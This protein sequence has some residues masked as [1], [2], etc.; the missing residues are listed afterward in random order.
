MAQLRPEVRPIVSSMPVEGFALQTGGSAR[1]RVVPFDT[2]S[3]SYHVTGVPGHTH[4]TSAVCSVLVDNTER[5]NATFTIHENFAHAAVEHNAPRYTDS[6]AVDES[7]YDRAIERGIG[8]IAIIPENCHQEIR[9]PVRD[10][11]EIRT[12]VTPKDKLDTLT[13]V[14]E[15]GGF[16]DQVTGEVPEDEPTYPDIEVDLF[17][18]YQ[19]A[20]EVNDVVPYDDGNDVGT[21]NAEFPGT[22]LRFESDWT[23]SEFSRDGNGDGNGTSFAVLYLAASPDVVVTVDGVSWHGVVTF[24]WD[25]NRKVYFCPS[26]EA[27]F[28]RV[29]EAY[30]VPDNAGRIEYSRIHTDFEVQFPEITT[31]VSKDGQCVFAG[32][33]RP[34]GTG[35]QLQPIECT[36]ADS[37]L[38]RGIANSSVTFWAYPF[39]IATGYRSALYG[40]GRTISYWSRVRNTT[41]ERIMERVRDQAIVGGDLLNGGVGPEHTLLQSEICRV[42]LVDEDEIWRP[43]TEMPEV[44]ARNLKPGTAWSMIPSVLDTDPTACG[45]SFDINN[46]GNAWAKTPNANAS[47]G[48]QFMMNQLVGDLMGVDGAGTLNDPAWTNAA[49]WENHNHHN[50]YRTE[51][52]IDTTLLLHRI[53]VPDVQ[54][55]P[56]V[57]PLDHFGAL[58][59]ARMV[60]A[61]TLAKI[62]ITRI[63]AG[64]GNPAQ[65]PVVD[66]VNFQSEDH[67]IREHARRTNLQAFANTAYTTARGITTAHQ[68]NLNL[69]TGQIANAVA[70]YPTTNVGGVAPAVQYNVA[71]PANPGALAAVLALI[72]PI[73]QQQLVTAQAA[74][75][76]TLE[77]LQGLVANLV[78][79]NSG[80]NFVYGALPTDDKRAL[81]PSPTDADGHPATTWRQ[82]LRSRY[83]QAARDLVNDG[84][85]S[86]AKMITVPCTVRYMFADKMVSWRPA[87]AG[88]WVDGSTIDTIYWGT[89]ELGLDVDHA[90][91]TY[92]QQE[93]APF[94]IWTEPA[95]VEGGGD[96]QATG[97][98]IGIDTDL[99]ALFDI[100]SVHQDFTEEADANWTNQ[101]GDGVDAV[102][103]NTRRNNAAGRDVVI[104]SVG[105]LDQL[106]AASGVSKHEVW[107]LMFGSGN[108]TPVR[109]GYDYHALSVGTGDRPIQ[110]ILGNLSS[111]QPENRDRLGLNRTHDTMAPA[112]LTPSI[113]A[114]HNARPNA[115]ALEHAQDIIYITNVHLSFKKNRRLFLVMNDRLR[116]AADGDFGAPTIFV[117]DSD[118]CEP[119]LFWDEFFNF[120]NIITKVRNLRELRRGATANETIYDIGD[121][122]LDAT[123]AT[124]WALA[125]ADPT[126]PGAFAFTAAQIT[127]VAA[128]CGSLPA[129]V[130]QGYHGA[131][132]ENRSW[133]SLYV[134][135]LAYQD[136]YYN[137]EPFA[138]MVA[139][140]MVRGV[141]H[142]SRL[143]VSQHLCAPL[144]NP[145]R[146]IGCSAPLN[147]DSMHLP[148]ELRDFR[149]ELRDR[150]FSFLPGSTETATLESLVLYEFNGGVQDSGVQDSMIYMPHFRSFSTTTNTQAF[151]LEVFSPYGNPSYI[152][153]FARSKVRPNE[154]AKQPL[155]KTLSI[156]SS[157]TMKKSNTI[158]EAREHEL[159]HLTQRN[160]HPRAEYNRTTNQNRQVVLLC[161]EDIGDMG[162]AEYQ[163]QKRARFL[164][165]GLVDVPAKI[166]A[167]FIYNNRGISIKNR[168][169]GVVRV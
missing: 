95:S 51:R 116:T 80:D 151:E 42:N 71:A 78:A 135:S 27:V 37:P 75:A 47:Q 134:P 154:F 38:R 167:L 117:F 84:E 165:S 137:A 85:V 63:D 118:D 120:S 25:P 113:V 48:L 54:G 59:A 157:T 87:Q 67:Y 168:E 111:T 15:V 144:I 166:T 29:R 53:R 26:F 107:P 34:L 130:A 61:V 5:S 89:R 150:D 33:D 2:S 16:V 163:V 11:Y 46:A 128:R 69:A 14:E 141:V 40:V 56:V 68:Q 49:N 41:V 24:R 52:F 123:D 103:Q 82:D 143:R 132:M 129:Y 133:A 94:Q 121:F 122:A 4:N 79:I 35:G 18:E 17:Q 110:R 92:Q 50:F 125:M 77:T 152:A 149:I 105:P 12:L 64:T 9:E 66:T 138:Q 109:V 8:E 100:R 153:L 44:S 158:L 62:A 145:N 159:F 57:T 65:V 10:I 76:Q 156:H 112:I 142:R 101:A 96:T 83:N 88:G 91:G 28:V 7:E 126:V 72:V 19:G 86:T 155:I 127:S 20:I 45:Y 6:A 73:I 114:A 124:T 58:V 115:Q 162:I 108:V 139:D 22:E 106:E 31:T 169:I 160:V 119:V 60:N 39:R 74:E 1:R 21:G 97:I 70:G 147:Y 102:A 99:Q 136:T 3:S 55:Q 13:Y 98:T 36:V 146:R 43:A 131:K 23:G 104:M 93:T 90:D 140:S 30:N 148:P 164:F 81:F 32:G 161:A